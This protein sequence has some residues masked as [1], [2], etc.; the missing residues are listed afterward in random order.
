MSNVA[1]IVCFISAVHLIHLLF[2]VL[3]IHVISAIQIVH[4]I[5][6]LRLSVHLDS[7]HNT[8]QLY[9]THNKFH[10]CSTEFEVY[11]WSILQALA[12]GPPSI[13]QETGHCFDTIAEHM[14]LHALGTS[15]CI[16][17]WC[18]H[19]QLSACASVTWYMLSHRP[20]HDLHHKKQPAQLH[21]HAQTGLVSCLPVVGWW[22]SPTGCRRR[23]LPWA[24]QRAWWHVLHHSW[25]E[26]P[27]SQW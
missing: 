12:C 10:L 6:A 13:L 22:W 7:T 18:Q 4:F 21:T 19:L 16:L 26:C 3:M 1:Q 17:T 25:A 9:K 15:S 14:T 11:P 27:Q 23:A 24:G 2:A 8:V 5:S 20:S